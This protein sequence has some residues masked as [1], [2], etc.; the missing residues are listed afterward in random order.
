[1]RGGGDTYFKIEGRPFEDPNQQVTA[2]NP[3]I[4]HDYFNAMGISLL[5]G[6]QFTEHE[7]REPAKT[8]IINES[9]ARTYFPN[10]DP[11][12][13]GLIIDMGEPRT[14]EIIGVTRDIRQFSL[15]FDASPTM[16]LPSINTGW[17]NLVVRT[18]GD[19]LAMTTA[20]RSAVQSI[21]RDQPLANVRSM[22]QI[23]AS[24]VAEPRFRTT[25]LSAFAML[26]LALAGVGIYGVMSYSV[27]RRT[28]EIGIRMALG[29]R[30]NDT[31]KLV[32]G[33]GMALSLIGVTVGL[34]G[35][36]G[37]TRLLS[38]LLFGISAT[39][40]FTFGGIALLLIGV[41]GVACYIPARRATKVDPMQALRCE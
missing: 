28:H 9:F 31:L 35:A 7:T 40:P 20:I 13:K 8:V 37:L 12:G 41:A 26:A 5:K 14:C 1:M 38:S 3:A 18:T 4:S 32:V 23:L 24:S 15:E 29:A 11:L 19:P 21:D 34:A 33:H 16:Y 6:R 30:P 27:A 22:E 10:E 2:L 39:D 36:F 25:L 17:P